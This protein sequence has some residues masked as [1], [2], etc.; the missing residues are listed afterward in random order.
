M[1]SE[2]AAYFSNALPDTTEI[3]L[4][5]PESVAAARSEK[6]SSTAIG[7]IDRHSEEHSNEYL[8]L[9]VSGGSKEA[10]SNLFQRHA[11]QVF[12]VARRILRDDAEAEDLLQ[13][14]FL[15]LFQKAGTFDA[16]KSSAIS[17]IIQMTY[18]RAIDRR[19]Y[20]AF[21]QHYNSQELVDER[22]HTNEGH[23]SIDDVAGR[24][25]LNKLRDELSEE[26]RQTLE[27]HFFEGYTFHEIAER[28]GQ[29][30]GNVR[31]HYYR[32]LE[33]LRSFVFPGKTRPK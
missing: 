9:Q 21:R 1:S 5:V 11:R 33:R 4:P 25:L 22:Q 27:L 23:I 16:K 18:H 8:L 30:F 12:H 26:Q 2:T 14:V 20:L 17:W 24:T 7:T 28:T 13:D 32:G 6:D 3:A 19:R 15:F 31:H 10:L 29:G